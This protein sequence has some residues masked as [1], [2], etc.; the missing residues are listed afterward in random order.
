MT[1]TPMIHSDPSQ[2]DRAKAIQLLRLEILRREAAA[3]VSTLPEGHRQVAQALIL[4]AEALEE[5]G[6]HESGGQAD[7]DPVG[8]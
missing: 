4:A 1:T 5:V 6:R 3:R 8:L 2:M 7:L